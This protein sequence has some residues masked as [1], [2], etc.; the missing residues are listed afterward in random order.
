MSLVKT[1]QISDRY[2][3]GTG[4]TFKLK[5][6]SAPEDIMDFGM[7]EE[8]DAAENILMFK[9]TARTNVMLRDSKGRFVSYKNPKVQ[10]DIQA[11]VDL[12]IPFPKG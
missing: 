1:I 7:M 3:N 12:L 6:A 8:R 2:D 9:E 4:Q 11:A 10:E 5:I